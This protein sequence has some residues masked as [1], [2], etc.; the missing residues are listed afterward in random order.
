MFCK[1]NEDRNVLFGVDKLILI[2][3]QPYEFHDS[4]WA[5]FLHFGCRI[6]VINT[7]NNFSADLVPNFVYSL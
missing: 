6:C 5:T 1:N 4:S 2:E 7:S 3:L